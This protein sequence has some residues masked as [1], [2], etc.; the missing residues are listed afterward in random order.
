[1][2]DNGY[3]SEELKKEMETLVDTKVG[4]IDWKKHNRNKLK[5][6]VIF[7]IIQRFDNE[8]YANEYKNKDFGVFSARNNIRIFIQKEIDD[9]I[10]LFY[11]K[12]DEKMPIL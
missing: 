7:N 10:E 2:C 4:A 9:L 12:E 11:K 1:M 5:E 8:F 6:Q 3:V